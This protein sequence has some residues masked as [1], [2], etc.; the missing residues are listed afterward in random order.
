M[1]DITMEPNPADQPC[2]VKHSRR[3]L[4]LGAGFAAAAAIG[5]PLVRRLFS[6]PTPVFLARNQR[7]D[8]PLAD[9]IIA[10]LTA[11]GFDRG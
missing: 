11:V 3:R 8:G 6:A 5:Y 1:H 4:L 9:T 10:G 7:Y 2:H